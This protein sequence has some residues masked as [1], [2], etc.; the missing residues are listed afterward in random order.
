MVR[1]MLIRAIQRK[2]L[3][4]PYARAIHDMVPTTPYIAP[5]LPPT[6]HESINDLPV[7]GL[8]RP[9]IFHPT[10]ESSPFNRV[11]AGRVFSAAPRSLPGAQPRK[12]EFVG[13]V[14]VEEEILLPAEDRIPHPHLVEFEKDKISVEFRNEAQERAERYAQRLMDDDLRRAEAQRK[15]KARKEAQI[16]R[17]DDGRRWEFRVQ[18]V[19]ASRDRTG[20]TGRGTGAPGMRYGAPNDE[21]KR[22]KVK[23]PT[24][25]NV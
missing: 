21:R 4:K 23:I 12:R 25:I 17:I 1:H 13:K 10:S 18:D 22:G 16:T 15:E 7:H 14:G 11:D 6:P 3:A 8:T 5:P 2:P 9:Q 20:L 24:R 19:V